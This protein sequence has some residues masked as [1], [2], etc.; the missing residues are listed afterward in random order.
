[1]TNSARWVTWKYA[2]VPPP[3][4]A[5]LDQD[6]VAQIFLLVRDLYKKEGGKFPGPDSES[7]LG[8]RGPESAHPPLSQAAME[9][10]GRA[11]ADLTDPT[12]GQ[13][14]KTGQQLPGFAWLKDDGTTM[15]GN[16]IYSGCWTEAGA[17]IQ[18]RGTEDPSDLGVYP[19]WA[20][21]WPANRRVLYNRASCDTAGSPWDPDRKQIWWNEGSGKW[22]G[23]DVPG[24][25]NP[26]S[27]PKDHMGPF[28]MNPEG[29]ARLF[30]PIGV[31]ADGPFPE[32]YEPIESPIKNPLHPDQS[33]NPLVKKFN[34]PYDKFG[35]P[36]EYSIICTYDVSTDR[37]V[38][39][40]D[41]K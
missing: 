26:A 38:S 22:V 18:R 24:F 41:E 4:E 33:N 10:N 20:W 12:T 7:Q 30:A 2:A 11:L 21:S 39:L 40:L 9:L 32:H 13:V 23:D 35:T 15:C 6:I 34:T 37:A 27:H 1:M 28:I 8:L 31:L 29:V 5:R 14:V 3:G 19:N 17:N 25:A 36:E 16:W